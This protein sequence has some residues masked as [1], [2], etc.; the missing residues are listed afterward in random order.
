MR[1]WLLVVLLVACAGNPLPVRGEEP[2]RETEE[3]VVEDE[4]LRPAEIFADDAVETEV[5]EAEEIERLPAAN[6]ADIVARLPGI[7]TPQRIQGEQAAVSIEGMPVEYTQILVDGQRFSGEIGGVA[8]PRRLPDRERRPHRDPARQP[9]RALRHRS[10]RR[11]DQR[12]HAARPRE[13]RA[14]RRRGGRRHRRPGARR[15]PASGSGLGKTGVTVS[16]GQHDVDGFEFPEGL[17]F[18]PAQAG[19]ADT[20][21]SERNVYG[22]IDHDLREDLKLHTRLGWRR[23]DDDFAQDPDSEEVL[24]GGPRVLSRKYET[25]TSTT[26]FHWLAGEATNVTG[27]F[28]YYDALTDSEVGREFVQDEDQSKVDL[29][30]DHVLETGPLSHVLLAALDFRRSSFGL[31]NAALPAGVVLDGIDVGG[32]D[33]RFYETGLF[34]E[35]ETA[36]LE[37]ATLL[38][39]LRLQTHSQFQ[40]ALLPQV[41]LMLTPHPTLKIRL[42]WGRNQRN[43]SLRDLFQPPS[44]QQGGYFLAGNPNLQP[45][46]SESWRAGFEWSPLRFASVSVTGF[47]NDFDDSIRSVL[48]GTV[49]VGSNTA[50]GGD[51]LLPPEIDSDFRQLCE[52]PLVSFRLPGCERF[53]DGGGTGGGGATPIPSNL[54]RKQN[55][56]SV[57]TRGV[58]VRLDLRPHPRVELELGYTLLD[59]EVRDSDRP[60]LVE[61]PNE[62]KN[63]IDARLYVTVPRSETSFAIEAEWRDRA[64]IETSGTGLLGF[65]DPATLSEP[66]F[67]LNVRIAQPVWRNVEV[68]LDARNLTDERIIDSYPIRGRTFFLGVR[69]SFHPTWDLARLGGRS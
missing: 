25:W 47:W 54:F 67:L 20:E 30:V 44:L 33:E 4:R 28:T 50:G 66:A 5:I 45:E 58:E 53:S 27:D 16:G 29:A 62:P 59:T 68:F 8:R 1:R 17:R 46:S 31:E 43:P 52:D 12:H 61:L 19:D 11:R 26:G 23:E 32:V 10:R 14:L 7:R 18:T 55:L 13:R 36:F 39:A 40:E 69:A 9:G 41:G 51:G 63:V 57:R 22:T 49:V 24:A 15:R 64:I 60:E 48:D 38:L 3:I 56:D 42:G 6:A 2:V 35:S 34:V 65:A 37:W 21:Y